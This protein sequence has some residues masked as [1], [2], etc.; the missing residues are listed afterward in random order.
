MGILT[1]IKNRWKEKGTKAAILAVIGGVGTYFGLDLTPDQNLAVVAFL[2]VIIS[3]VT[4][5]TKTAK[6]EDRDT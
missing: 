1:W 4:A 3:L 2:G 5:G 6:A